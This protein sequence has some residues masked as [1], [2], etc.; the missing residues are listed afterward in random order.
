MR[1]TG[2]VSSFDQNLF[3]RWKDF[4]FMGLSQPC[5][6]KIVVSAYTIPT[7]APEA[8]GTFSWDSTTLVLIEIKA[9]GETGL[10]YTYGN[11]A[12]RVVAQHI[13]E[14]CLLRESSFDISRLHASM[15]RQVRNDGSRGIASM[16]ISALDVALWD[17]KARLLECPIAHLLGSVQTSVPVYGSGG[18]T[19]YS[20]EQL[21]GQ[22]SGWAQ[23]GI[24][25]VK[26]K[27]GSQPDADPGRVRIARNAIGPD[28]ALFIDANGA[29]S[30]KQA[31]VL[32]H[33]FAE[34]NVIWFEEPVSSDHLADLH[35]VRDA[36]PLGMEIAAGEYGYDSLYFRRMLEAEAVDVLQLDAT[37][38]KGFTGF[39][40]GAAIA[41]SFGCPLSAHC[42][43][44]LHM[45]VACAVPNFRHVEYFHD[46]ARIEE[47]LFDGF[48]AAK[49]GQLQP[50]RSAPGLGLTFKHKDA[51][52][53][54]A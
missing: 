49:D 42:A 53:Y 10:G 37:R 20:N 13:G 19:S 25:S 16:A 40:Q 39:L 4:L 18:F 26:M 33:T 30:T 2:C 50:N 43:P 11:K 22:L 7:D 21:T 47:M 35:R 5:I 51:E 12:V 52:R 38:C 29:Y 44:T 24:K 15:I 1:M 23:S 17:L 45:H 28:V 31:I 46:H 27:I 36:A 6:E 9:G 34:C 32:A 3:C 54:S 14:K 41:A 48:I 8:D